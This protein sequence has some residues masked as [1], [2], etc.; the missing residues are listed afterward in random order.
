M[1]GAIGGILCIF[2]VADFA[3]SWMGINLTPFLPSEIARF[4]PI[5]I[6]GIGALLIKMDDKKEQENENLRQFVAE[7]KKILAEQKK[8]K[9][10]IKRSKKK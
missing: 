8:A 3:L 9:T 6:G 1:L 5:I 4:S 10:K 2:A 7:G